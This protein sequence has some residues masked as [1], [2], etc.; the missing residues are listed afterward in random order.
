MKHGRMIH[1]LCT[2]LGTPTSGIVYYTVL[3]SRSDSCV[4]SRGGAYQA[5]PSLG[6]T[7]HPNEIALA[8][9]GGALPGMS[10][11]APSAEIIDAHLAVQGTIRSYQVN[12]IALFRRKVF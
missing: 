2:L 4:S 5:P 6:N 10:G 3:N 1:P 12:T 9:L 8:S 7:T 11:G